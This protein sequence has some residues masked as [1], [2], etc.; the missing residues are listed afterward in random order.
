VE[1]SHIYKKTIFCACRFCSAFLGIPLRRLIANG[2]ELSLTAD[3]IHA[4]QFNAMLR[5]LK[6]EKTKS[7][8]QREINKDKG[9]S[10]RKVK[11]NGI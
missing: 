6:G 5:N 11:R 9:K 4:E 2:R 7:K 10:I 3:R 1:K 8:E